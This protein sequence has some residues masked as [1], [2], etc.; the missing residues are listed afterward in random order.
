MQRKPKNQ[1]TL[2]NPKKGESAGSGTISTFDLNRR[3]R[4]SRRQ[5]IFNHQSFVIFTRPARTKGLMFE[6]HLTFNR[7]GE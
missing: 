3:S 4:L 7:Q 6:N 2:E 5:A 1:R